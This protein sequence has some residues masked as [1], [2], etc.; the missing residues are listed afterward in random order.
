MKE[1]KLKNIFSVI[2]VVLK[3]NKGYMLFLTN[4]RTSSLTCL[5]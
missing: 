2:K 4:K 3:I 5:G 1:V